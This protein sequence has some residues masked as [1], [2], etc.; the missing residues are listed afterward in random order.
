MLYSVQ[1]T[2]D[3]ELATQKADGIV[4][5]TDDLPITDDKIDENLISTCGVL[6]TTAGHGYREVQ[7]DIDITFNIST[8]PDLSQFGQRLLAHNY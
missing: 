5:Y 3:T 1:P 6:C 8:I 4:F 7:R 2:M